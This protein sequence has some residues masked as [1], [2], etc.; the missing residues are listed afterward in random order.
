MALSWLKYFGFLS[1]NAF[2][3]SVIEELQARWEAIAR[4]VGVEISFVIVTNVACVFRNI[5]YGFGYVG[6]LAYATRRIWLKTRS[7]CIIRRMDLC[8]CRNAIHSL[9]AVSCILLCVLQFIVV[10]VKES[11]VMISFYFLYIPVT[12]EELQA[13]GEAIARNVDV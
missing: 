11:E 1:E 9:L 8:G 12:I 10:R 4:N 6:L 2:M 5:Q 3:K 7:R 13:R